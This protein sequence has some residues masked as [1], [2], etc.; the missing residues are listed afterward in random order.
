M[1]TEPRT[2]IRTPGDGTERKAGEW[3]TTPA[4]RRRILDA[5]LGCF[6]KK[7]VAAT[8]IDDIRAASGLTVG[9][10]YHHFASKDDVFDQLVQE[11][12]A[13][14]LAGITD[15]LEGGAG[16][17]ES[18]RRLV[19]FHVR[20]VEERP[21]LTKLMLSWEESERSRPGGREHYR[22]YS[23]AIGAWLRREALA[24]RIRRMEPDL[25]SALLMGPLMEYARQRSGGITSASP[26]TIERGLVD[27]LLRVLETGRLDK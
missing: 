25:Y 3:G 14:Y 13:E 18:V 2:R 21:A 16:V 17:E 6:D 9:S 27:G 4:T 1:P 10:I 8:T 12:M 15:A 20:W 26:R 7:G 11:A 24:G 22:Q 5:A 19:R 23:N